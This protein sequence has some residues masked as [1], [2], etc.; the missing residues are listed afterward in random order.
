MRALIEGNYSDLVITQDLGIGMMLWMTQFFPENRWAK[1]QRARSLAVPNQMWQDTGYFARE[2]Y[3]PDVRNAFADY[4]VSVGLRFVGAMADRVERR[5]PISRA[6]AQVTNMT[7]P[8]SPMQWRAPP[9]FRGLL[10]RQD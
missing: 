8:P 1:L 7:A 4:G 10:L 3:L 6:I 5:T 9:I 2:P